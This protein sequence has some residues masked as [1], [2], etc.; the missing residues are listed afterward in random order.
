MMICLCYSV[1][2]QDAR[3]YDEKA[4]I[5]KKKERIRQYYEENKERL[6]KYLVIDTK[7]FLKRKT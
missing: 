7:H 4:K 6:Q 5:P 2:K 1:T 3:D